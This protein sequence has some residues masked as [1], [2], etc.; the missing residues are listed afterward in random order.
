MIKEQRNLVDLLLFFVTEQ[1]FY[2]VEDEYIDSNNDNSFCREYIF[3]NKDEQPV[4]DKKI[5]K[6]LIDDVMRYPRGNRFVFPCWGKYRKLAVKMRV[7]SNIYYYLT[8]HND[9][10]VLPCRIVNEK[11]EIDTS[12]KL[13]DFV[14]TKLKNKDIGKEEIKQLYDDLSKRISEILK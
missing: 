8:Y 7:F 9:F 3:K 2:Y 12:D 14:Y 13:I 1:N 4:S 11:V 5:K 10:M 6:F